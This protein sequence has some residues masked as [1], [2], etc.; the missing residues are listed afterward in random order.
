M[1]VRIGRTGTRA[2]CIGGYDFRVFRF[3]EV[4]GNVIVCIV[5][6]EFFL[7]FESDITVVT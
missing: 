6:F 4:C 1:I 5:S 3:E 7:P 2:K